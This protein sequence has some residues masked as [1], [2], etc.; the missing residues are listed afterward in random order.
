MKKKDKLF[1]R[2]DY[3]ITDV[4]L[5]IVMGAIP[6]EFVEFH[7]NTG[8]TVDYFIASFMEHFPKKELGEDWMEIFGNSIQYACDRI[9]LDIA[10]R[11]DVRVLDDSQLCASFCPTGKLGSELNMNKSELENLLHSAYVQNPDLRGFLMY[12]PAKG[13][14]VSSF[15]YNQLRKA[16]LSLDKFLK[17]IVGG[18]TKFSVN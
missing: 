15:F 1:G 3:R 13:Y 6:T 10:P 16:G 7:P 4:N 8:I 14:V 2:T 18:K 9:G 17:N 11:E 12:V 5:L